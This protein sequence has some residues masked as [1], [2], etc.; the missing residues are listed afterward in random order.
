M[1]SKLIALG[2]ELLAELARRSP[3]RLL[4]ISDDDDDARLGAEVEC[5]GCFLDALCQGGFPAG[6][7]EL[8]AL[9]MVTAAL[10]IGLKLSLTL[11]WFQGPGP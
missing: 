1:D 4:S 11:H 6:T 8:T 7:I 9:M 2:A 10:G 3:A 5:L